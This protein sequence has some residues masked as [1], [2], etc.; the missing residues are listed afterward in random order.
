MTSSASSPLS[1]PSLLI[2]DDDPLIIDTLGYVLEDDF[3]L[4]SADNR[5]AAIATVRQRG[6]RLDLALIDLGLPPLPNR[7]DEGL[8]LIGEL[9]AHDPHCKIIVLS[10]QNEEAHARH[11]RTLGALEFIAKPAQPETLRAALQRAL[12]LRRQ[13]LDVVSASQALERIV[14]ESAP[15]LAAR[16]QLQRFAN[17]HFPVLIEGESGAGKEVAAQA[18]H[19]LAGAQRRFVALNCAA[20]APGL[21]EATL[22]GHTRGAFTGAQAAQTGYFEEAADGT[23][24]LDEIGELPLEL[25]PKLLR[26]LENGEYQRVGETQKRI[27]RARIIAATNRDLQQ[28]VRGGRFRAD[29]FHR[30]SVLRVRMPALRQT[31]DDRLILLDHYIRIFSQQ[32]Q[33]QPFRLTADALQCWQ[34]YDFP[35][36]V[37]ELR[38][39][40]IRLLVRYAGQAVSR[41]ELESEQEADVIT[42]TADATEAPLS[43]PGVIKDIAPGGVDLPAVLRRVE[44]DY[45]AA[46]LQQSHGNM[47]QAARLLGINRSTLYNRMETL[48][49]HGEDLGSATEQDKL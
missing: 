1:Q 44:R 7:P 34:A 13:E 45:I 41:A 11:A 20:I 31:G 15:I 48:A 49:R 9:L 5:S 24:F 10:G 27:V 28:E 21:I 30:L 39:I 25:Q 47:S 26:V 29:L 2:V 4:L 18:L 17:S 19:E 6:G 12:Q 35:G 23:L 16:A 22:F 37:R 42:T 43:P 14:G 33:L 46:A 32:M 36:N 3:E 8:A 38:N 40:V